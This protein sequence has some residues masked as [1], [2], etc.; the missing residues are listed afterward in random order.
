MPPFAG[1]EP[2]P[3]TLM[4]TNG[5]RSPAILDQW[6]SLSSIWITR[7]WIVW[8]RSLGGLTRSSASM[9]CRPQRGHSWSPL[10]KTA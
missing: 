1:S 3:E 5:N 8:G 7:F 10:T 2:L 4:G 9:D 6:A